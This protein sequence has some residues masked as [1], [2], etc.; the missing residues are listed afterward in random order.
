MS[1]SFDTVAG[2][3]LPRLA[4]L[5]SDSPAACVGTPTAAL[6]GNVVLGSSRLVSCG[7]T[8]RIRNRPFQGIAAFPIVPCLG[9]TDAN[10]ILNAN[11][12]TTF[13]NLFAAGDPAANCDGSTTTLTANN[14]SCFLNAYAAGCP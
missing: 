6:S 11:D 5:N 4:G 13:L 8:M 2:R 3:Y 12:F 1:G 7:N 10:C 14:F 9:A